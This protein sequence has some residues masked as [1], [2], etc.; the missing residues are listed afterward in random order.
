MYPI[1]L[2]ERSESKDLFEMMKISSFDSALRAS[3]R[4][5]I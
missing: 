2:S 4:I 5:G 3:L 1:I